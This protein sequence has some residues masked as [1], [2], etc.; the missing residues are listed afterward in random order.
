MGAGATS[1]PKHIDKE[2]FRQLSGGTLNDGLFDAYSVD[3]IMTRDKLIEIANMKD[4]YLSHDWSVDCYGRNVYQRVLKINQALR[5]KGLLT[6]FNESQLGADIF[7]QVCSG[8]DKSRSIVCFLTRSYLLKVA[9]SSASDNC[10]MEFSYSLHKKYP[11]LMI[12]VVFEEQLLNKAL[13]SGPVQLALSQF[14]YIDFITDDN[15]DAKID[16]LYQRIMKISRGRNNNFLYS[17]ESIAINNAISMQTNKSKEAQQFFQWLGRSTTIEESRRL[18]YCN[19]IIKNGVISVQE[20]AKTMNSNSSFLTTIGIN[21]YDAD[22]IAL[23]L[24]DLG[25]GYAPVRDFSHSN[26]L[27]SVVFA[28]K[29]SDLSPNDN[30]IAQNALAC[31]ARVA[32]SNQISP[33]ILHDAGIGTAVLKIMQRS[34]GHAPAIEFGCLSIHNLCVKDLNI[35]LKLGE[36]GGACDILP[37]SIRSHIDNPNVVKNGCEAIA[38]L[39]LVKENRVKFSSSSGCDVTVKSLLR[40]FQDSAVAEKCCFAIYNLAIKHAENLNK[41]VISGACEAIA[42]ALEFHPS[43]KNIVDSV[44]KIM[45]TLGTEPNSRGKLGAETNSCIALISALN[46]MIDA[47]D[48]T[49][50]GICEAIAAITT[51]NAFNR[52]KFGQLGA[53]EVLKQV[54]IKYQNDPV[55][56]Q[57]VCKAIFSLVAGSVEHKQ[58]FNGL[59]VLLQSFIN[60]RN[61]H[62]G[63]KL[64]AKEVLNRL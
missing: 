56:L 22:Q 1:L 57:A 32:G 19:A 9:N 31:V 14:E 17:Q 49:V 60:N 5:A 21:E 45:C 29:K 54:V 37:R 47:N 62:D 55:V 50:A 3:G 51:G 12:P 43:N 24:S 35:A 46:A 4:C 48:E 7:T 10:N 61:M 30:V 63:V 33:S 44:T 25:L 6:S 28:L 59:Q 27:E 42:K 53:C 11:E 52:S 13:W 38:T 64:E 20:L 39:A 34:L 36:L 15:F 2:K 26:T 16:K 18:I 23:A 41:L 8:I 40:H 58:K